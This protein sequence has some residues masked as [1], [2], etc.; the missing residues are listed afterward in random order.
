MK[1]GSQAKKWFRVRILIMVAGVLILC[2]L[3]F[4]MF[5]AVAG[6]P[7]VPASAMALEVPESAIFFALE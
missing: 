2:A 6:S 7:R 1:T 3:E 4:S 5:C